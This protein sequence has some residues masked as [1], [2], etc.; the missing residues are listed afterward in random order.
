MKK[1]AAL[2]ISLFLLAFG[3]GAVAALPEKSRRAM[4]SP[5]V[6]GGD[7]GLFNLADSSKPGFV[8]TAS[9]PL[10]PNQPYGWIIRLRTDKAKVK[11]REEF[12]LP[13]KPAT[14]GTAEE[15]GTRSV[16]EDGRTSVTEREVAPDQGLIFNTWSVA[17]GD[18]AGKYVIRVFVEGALAK[19]FEFEV[20]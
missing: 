15:L 12:T 2:A 11:W 13:V 5:I 14:W 4:A 19:T 8:P 9:V 7:F 1:I 20:R 16:S 3:L 17:A 18:P 10:I 6:I